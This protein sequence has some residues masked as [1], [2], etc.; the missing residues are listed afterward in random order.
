MVSMLWFGLAVF[1]G[2]I[3]LFFYRDFLILTFITA[4]YTSVFSAMGVNNLT[5]SALVF[6]GLALAFL[7]TYKVIFKGKLKDEEA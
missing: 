6:L 2:L 4:L 1:L 7:V 5:D 3:C